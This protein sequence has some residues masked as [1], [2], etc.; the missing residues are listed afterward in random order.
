MERKN[1]ELP[2]HCPH[3]RGILYGQAAMLVSYSVPAVVNGG[4]HCGYGNARYL[5]G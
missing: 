3:K 4:A 2:R 1:T 5:G